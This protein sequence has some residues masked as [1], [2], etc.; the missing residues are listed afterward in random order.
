MFHSNSM[1]SELFIYEGEY[2]QAKRMISNLHRN[3][4][5]TVKTAFSH[6]RKEKILTVSI[7]CFIYLSVSL[8]IPVLI[9]FRYD[10][11]LL[12]KNHISYL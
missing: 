12:L 2:T 10:T 9:H 4:S 5:V 6:C 8:F 7:Y 3:C 11:T 1:P